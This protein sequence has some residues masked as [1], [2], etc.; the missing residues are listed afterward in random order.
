MFAQRLTMVA[1]HYYR[2]SRTYILTQPEQSTRRWNPKINL[3]IVRV[4]GAA[5]GRV[6]WLYGSCGSTDEQTK[7]GP[8][9]SD[10]QPSRVFAEHYPG[11]LD[12]SG[13][14]FVERQT[15]LSGSSRIPVQAEF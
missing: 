2:V 5:T 1:Y 14:M 12:V 9:S 10:S 8:F 6:G 4:P 11:A 13:E 15:K 7:N 3:E